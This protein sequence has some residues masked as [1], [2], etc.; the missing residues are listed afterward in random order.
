MFCCSHMSGLV[1]LTL[2]NS[3][4]LNPKLP[5]W[6]GLS[7]EAFKTPGFLGFPGGTTGKESTCQCKRRERHGSD[8]WVRKTS[9]SGKR[10]VALVFLPG[11]FHGKRNLEGY[12]PPGLKESDTTEQRST[13]PHFY[14]QNIKDNPLY[15][16]F[17]QQNAILRGDTSSNE[18]ISLQVSHY[19]CKKTPGFQTRCR[20]QS[21]DFFPLTPTS[22]MLQMEEVVQQV[23]EIKSDNPGDFVRRPVNPGVKRLWNL[24]WSD[25]GQVQAGTAVGEGVLPACLWVLSR[26]RSS[27]ICI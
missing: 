26:P 16:R 5:F 12:S 25:P 19:C 1:I 2:Y 23:T 8:P 11:K 6:Q 13:A 17:Q 18:H 14:L 24:E 20:M 10:Q 22:E 21:C 7:S 9:W 3:Y 4:Y 27:F 15:T